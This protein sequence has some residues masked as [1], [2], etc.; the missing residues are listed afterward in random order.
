MISPVLARQSLWPIKHVVSYGKNCT[1]LA[2]S[3]LLKWLLSQLTAS[4][5]YPDATLGGIFYSDSWTR[6]VAMVSE[7]CIAATGEIKS[8]FQSSTETPVPT[9]LNSFRRSITRVDVADWT[10]IFPNLEAI[11]AIS[12]SIENFPN[13]TDLTLATPQMDGQR[14]PQ[15]NFQNGGPIS[16]LPRGKSCPTFRCY[17]CKDP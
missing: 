4:H 15:G 16:Q 1:A 3:D 7:L 12:T 11:S 2:N 5:R 8:L 14:T 17:D 6:N 9:C 10:S 13:L